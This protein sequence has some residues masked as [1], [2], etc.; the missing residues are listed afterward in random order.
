[1]HVGPQW[2]GEPNLERLGATEG[3]VMGTACPGSREDREVG[4]GGNSGGWDDT[5]LDSQP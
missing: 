5:E 2:W 3:R 4:A 1:M